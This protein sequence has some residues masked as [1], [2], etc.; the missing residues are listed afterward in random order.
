VSEFGRFTK[1]DQQP[2]YGKRQSSGASI[3][4]A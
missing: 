3:A 4:L 2:S 1:G